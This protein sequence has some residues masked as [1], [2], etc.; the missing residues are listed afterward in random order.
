VG[1]A[2]AKKVVVIAE[3]DE[4]I[5]VLLRDA[6][7]DEHG[8]QAVIVSDGALLIDT[9]RQVRA[10]LVILDIMMPGLDGFEIF[11]RIRHDDDIKD[12]PILFVT[13]AATQYESDFRRRGITDVIS[14]PFDLNDLLAQVRTLC[15]PDAR[16]AHR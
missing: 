5:A 7:S 14:K 12:M 9:V 3:D 6:I 4:P 1:G 8:Y 13:A 11:D 10:D 16:A 15:P 2:T